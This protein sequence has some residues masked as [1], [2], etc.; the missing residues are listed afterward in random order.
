M[1]ASRISASVSA[2]GA[3]SYFAFVFGTLWQSDAD[4]DGAIEEN[5]LLQKIL[6]FQFVL[7]FIPDCV[8]NVASGALRACGWSQTIAT[9]YFCQHYILGLGLGLYAVTVYQSLEL[10]WLAVFTDL[11]VGNAVVFSILSG[12]IDWA[13]ESA[14]A[15]ARS[16]RKIRISSSSSVSGKVQRRPSF[17]T[18]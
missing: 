18:T 16:T 5:L 1:P 3:N 9:V 10:L 11:L 13:R 6:F 4:I 2:S 17:N 14:I 15:I 7:C 12:W 8:Q